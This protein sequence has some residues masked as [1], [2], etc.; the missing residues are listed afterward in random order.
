MVFLL[1]WQISVDAHALSEASLSSFKQLRLC[2]SFSIFLWFRCGSQPLCCS[3][4]SKLTTVSNSPDITSLTFRGIGHF[5]KNI[6][7]CTQAPFDR[8]ISFISACF[9]NSRHAFLKY[10][11]FTEISVP[12]WHF[13]LSSR[14]K[15]KHFEKFQDTAE[16]LAGKVNG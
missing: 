9:G 1:E 5:V 14:V 2:W 13:F 16:A 10:V 11:A 12:L 4:P 3:I 15:L 6:W 8:N 7:L